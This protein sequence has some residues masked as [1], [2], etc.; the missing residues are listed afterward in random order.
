MTA[1]NQKV[2]IATLWER[3]SAKGNS[4]LSGFLG[5][6]RVVAF[7]SKSTP[8]GTPTWNVYVTPGIERSETKAS[9]SSPP[10]IQPAGMPLD[11]PLPE[12][13]P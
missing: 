9:A 4:Y 3:T 8:A 12:D 5:R 13:W 2:L 1:P 10:H 7:R 6:A 11:N